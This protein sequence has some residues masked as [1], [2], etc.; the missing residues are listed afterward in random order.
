MKLIDAFEF[1]ANQRPAWKKGGKT[2]TT[3]F[4]I[5]RDHLLRLLG[6][7]KEV[8]KI[9][10]ACLA[11]L[12]NTLQSETVAGGER[13]SAASVNRIM[14]MLQTLL[15]TLED[16]EILTKAPKIKPFKE[17]NQRTTFFT[18]DEVDAMASAAIEIYDNKEL[19]DAILFAAYTGCRQSELLDLKVGDVDLV[20]GLITFRDTKNGSD[21]LLDIHPTL[22]S[23]LAVR[24]KGKDRADS[25]FGFNHKDALYR[26]FK[27]VRDYCGIPDDRV[28]HTLRHSTGTWMAEQGVPIQTIAKVLNHKQLTTT[29]RYVKT[30]DQARRTAINAL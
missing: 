8:K 3:P 6:A 15:N 29:Q 25:V 4:N 1:V 16:N 27:K 2:F 17:N 18:R 5:N 20:N 19:A 26:S 7:S 12:R 11:N 24:V 14:S 23:I 28:W 30:T 9:D 13:R 10:R 22:A 21:H